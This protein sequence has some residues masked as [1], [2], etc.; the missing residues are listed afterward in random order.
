MSHDLASHG[1]AGIAL[2]ALAPLLEASL[3][4]FNN[5]VI[6]SKVELA[7]LR[8]CAALAPSADLSLV[9]LGKQAFALTLLRATPDIL[10]SRPKAVGAASPK[11]KRE[12]Q[13]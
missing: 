12:N 7:S 5:V 13:L 2:G 3:I 4:L 6:Y 10:A 11:A 9:S 8:A 1:E